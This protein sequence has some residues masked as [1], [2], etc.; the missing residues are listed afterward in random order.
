[1]LTLINFLISPSAQIRNLKEINSRRL[2][3]EW[4]YI[5]GS[6]NSSKLDI[7]MYMYVYIY[8]YIYIHIHIYLY[9]TWILLSIHVFC[10]K[11]NNI[12]LFCK[13]ILSLLP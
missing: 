3:L 10:R 8:L 6:R 2:I 9:I 11:R 12:V 4:I 13:I 5:C 7:F 1:M